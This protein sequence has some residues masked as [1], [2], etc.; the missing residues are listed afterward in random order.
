MD[1]LAQTLDALDWPAVQAAL[2]KR[3]RTPMGRQQALALSPLPDVAAVHTALD[4][5]AEVL[6]L[7]ADG[8]YVPVGEVVDATEAFERAQRGGVLDKLELRS[9]A[10]AL[11]GMEQLA[12]YLLGT[13]VD[14]VV[15]REFAPALQIDAPITAQLADAFDDTG[16]LSARAFPVLGSLRQKIRDLHASIRNTLDDMVRG[17]TW[18]DILQDRFVT[19]RRDRYVVPVKANFKRKELGIVHGMSSSGQTAFIEPREVVVLNND[20]RLAEGELEA[21]ERR[22]LAH[23]SQLVSRIAERAMHGIGVA[24]TIDLACA[25][26][27]L[28]IDLDATRPIVGDRGVLE[29]TSARHPVL[30]LRGITVVPND[31]RIGPDQPILVVS[32]PNTGGKTIALKTMGLA[33]L[34]ASSGCYVP[35]AEGSRVDHFH[36]VAALIGDHQTVH[37]DHSSFSSHVEILRAMVEA[38]RHGCLFLIDEIASGTDPY[39]GAALAQAILEHFLETGPRAL[40]TTHFHRLK[41]VSAIDPR[42]AIAGMQFANGRPTYRMVPGASG[43]SHALDIAERLGMSPELLGRAR[44]HMDASERSLA[45]TLAAL[46]AERERAEDANRRAN[47]LARELEAQQERLEAREERIR[48]R[49]KE[50]E[51]QAAQGFLDRLKGAERAISA[52]VAELQRNPSHDAVASARA[53]LQTLSRLAPRV[54]TTP[55]PPPPAQLAIGDRV[56]LTKLGRD[57][58]VTALDGDRVTVSAGGLVVRAKRQE[59]ERLGGPAPRPNKPKRGKKKKKRGGTVPADPARTPIADAVRHPGNTVDLRGLRVDEGLDEVEQFLDRAV[60]SSLGTVFVLHGHGTGAM[61]K[62]V[63]E[64]LRQCHYVASSAPANADQGGDAYTVAS[65]R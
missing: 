50:L 22:I 20:L 10:R 52:V 46:D 59:L 58:E 21:A 23:L 57:G 19:Q 1:L 43:E 64:W 53:T 45:E 6:L 44:G 13:D 62:A 12:D 24:T 47:E 30:T 51:Q 60:L 14:I 32:G 27:V 37:G 40:V 33:A 29:L 31:L 15:L 7:E 38:S 28:A 55:T 9:A 48:A 34:L 3:A 26:A 36:T 61:K 25:R 63:R 16:D 39:Q 18:A 4:A 41:T 56:R 17:E 54:E 5:T 35:A 49:A 2:S 65:L 42:F 8:G 11:G